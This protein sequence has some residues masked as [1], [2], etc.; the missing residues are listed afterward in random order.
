VR[1]DKKMSKGKPVSLSQQGSINTKGR[2]KPGHSRD[3]RVTGG[4][5]DNA[6]VAWV[7]WRFP[8]EDPDNLLGSPIEPRQDLALTVTA[9]NGFTLTADRKNT[10]IEVVILYAP[11]DPGTYIITVEN[12]GVDRVNNYQL[13]AGFG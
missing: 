3:Y 7:Q 6:L 4:G 10:G 9:P 12:V 8:T 5:E 2:L 1:K 11:T 13:S